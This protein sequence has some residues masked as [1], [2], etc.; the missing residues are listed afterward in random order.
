MAAFEALLKPGLKTPFRNLACE[1][2]GVPLADASQR[3]GGTDDV[4]KREKVSVLVPGE[5]STLSL[6]K[7]R[8]DLRYNVNLVASLQRQQATY[9]LYQLVK[10]TPFD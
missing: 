2:Y 8:R 10:E 1:H 6:R 9:N 3:E 7:H 4:V 5:Q